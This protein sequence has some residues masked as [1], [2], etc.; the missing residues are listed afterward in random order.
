M[1]NLIIGI[2]AFENQDYHRAFTLLHP[3]AHSGNP[4]AQSI[5]ANMYHLGLGM[6]KNI[7]LAIQWYTKA[8]MQGEH[9]A[10]NNLGTIYFLGDDDI[11]PNEIEAH[12][13][14]QYSINQGFIHSPR[15]LVSN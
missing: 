2:S 8:A 7:S 1:S 13:W 6:N 4:Q 14:W 11:P 9:I 12:K 3:F 10:C 5:I 15:V